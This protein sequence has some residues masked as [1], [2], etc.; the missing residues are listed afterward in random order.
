L[1][2]FALLQTSKF[3]K[4]AAAKEGGAKTESGRC[5]GFHPF[6]PPLQRQFPTPPS[7]SPLFLDNSVLSKVS[8]L[9][10]YGVR[11]QNNV[12]QEYYAFQKKTTKT[13]RPRK[14][15]EKFRPDS[16]DASCGNSIRWPDARKK[17]TKDQK[18]SIIT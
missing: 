7:P 11:A 14:F 2:L 15:A 6:L 18:G 1:E 13:R 10:E 12:T 5:I 17:A 9:R 8:F 4:Y 3:L 16:Y